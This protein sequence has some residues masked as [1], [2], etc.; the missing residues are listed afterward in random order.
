MQDDRKSPDVDSGV[1]FNS[2]H[3]STNSQNHSTSHPATT[4]Q[5][6]SELHNVSRTSQGPKLKRTTQ[7]S[8]IGDALQQ[9]VEQPQGTQRF[10]NRSMMS[11]GVASKA[12]CLPDE[13]LRRFQ[14]EVFAVIMRYRDLANP[15][16]LLTLLVSNA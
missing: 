10:F 13:A 6:Q 3:P 4:S 1:A 2:N 9:L 7:N 14:T 12:E 8:A 11:S 15:Q 16:S 5:A